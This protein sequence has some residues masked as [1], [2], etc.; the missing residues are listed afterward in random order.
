VDRND[1]QHAEWMAAALAL[2]SEAAAAGEVPVGA[3]IVRNREIVGRGRNRRESDQ[4]PVAHA[5][6]IAIQDAARS[7]GSWRLDGCQ[8]YVT[9]EPCAMC[10]GALVLARI[11]ACVFGTADP[12]GGFCGSLG[13]LHEHPGLNH[14]FSVLGGVEGDACRDQLQQ[15]FR[16]LREKKRT[17]T[18]TDEPGGADSTAVPERWPSG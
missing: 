13:S 17:K 16:A 10:T 7:L 8:I 4:D 12:K 11:D 9:L 3:V 18:L 14:R 15:F 2:A 1:P 5:E 6:L